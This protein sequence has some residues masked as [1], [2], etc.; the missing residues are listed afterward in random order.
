MTCKDCEARWAAMRQAVLDYKIAS[1]LGHA[2][3]GAAEIV[4]VK[5]KTGAKG[6]TAKPMRKA[7]SARG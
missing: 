4:G 3:K 7:R 2:V 6:A 5:P 1:A